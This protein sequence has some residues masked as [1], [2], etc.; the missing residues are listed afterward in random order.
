MHLHQGDL[1]L[2]K[3]QALVFVCSLLSFSLP[4][5]SLFVTSKGC[6]GEADENNLHARERERKRETGK[7]GKTTRQNFETGGDDAS[8]RQDA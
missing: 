6:W 8:P 7:R 1:A 4:P 3:K 2:E 5:S